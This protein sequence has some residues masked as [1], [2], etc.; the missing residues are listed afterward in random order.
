MPLRGLIGPPPKQKAQPLK[1]AP[2]VPG[3]VRA[4]PS[5]PLILLFFGSFK[6]IHERSCRCRQSSRRTQS[7]R[8]RQSARRGHSARC[9]GH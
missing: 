1:G 4:A 8:C 3:A 9:G 6:P 2:G 5:W 7:R